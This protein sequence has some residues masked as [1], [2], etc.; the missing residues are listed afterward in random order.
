MPLFAEGA[1]KIKIHQWLFEVG[2]QVKAGDNLVEAMTDKISI[3]IEAPKTGILIEKLVE[4]D[5]TVRIDQ[6]IAIIDDGKDN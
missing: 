3:N 1:T 6:V 5:D 2:D 4:E